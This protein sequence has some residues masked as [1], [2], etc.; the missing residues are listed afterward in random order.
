M[1]NKSEQLAIL[2]PKANF[3]KLTSL[4]GS[5]QALTRT[6]AAGEIVLFNVFANERLIGNVARV[7]LNFVTHERLSV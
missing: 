5:L 1:S 2:I 3:T 6:A 7:S 4:R